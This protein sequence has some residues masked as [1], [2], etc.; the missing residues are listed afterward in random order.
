MA[1]RVLAR[2]LGLRLYLK[3]QKT[4][5]ASAQNRRETVPA[6]QYSPQSTLANRLIISASRATT[7]CLLCSTELPDRIEGA[8]ADELKEVSARSER[9]ASGLWGPLVREKGAVG[10]QM[11][12]ILVQPGA[13]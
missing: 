10:G 7:G 1:S 13:G 6:R 12:F 8:R 11:A 3:F 4:S 5:A 9:S 2:C